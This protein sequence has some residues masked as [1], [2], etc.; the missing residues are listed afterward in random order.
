[1]STRAQ[2]RERAAE[3][4]QGRR[5]AD[6]VADRAAAA[7]AI[8]AEY[9]TAAVEAFERLMAAQRAAWEQWGREH[10]EAWAVRC[11]KLGELE[12]RKITEPDPVVDAAAEE[13]FSITA[14]GLGQY[15]PATLEDQ[16]AEDES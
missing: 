16:A 9:S 14:E 4:A 6:P 8:Y 3:R 1:M 11:R 12:D 13:G 5:S 10:A 15:G 2:R 7:A